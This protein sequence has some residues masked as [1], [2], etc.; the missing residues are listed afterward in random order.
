MSIGHLIVVDDG[1]AAWTGVSG[2]DC[3]GRTWLVG[4]GWRSQA[5]QALH[6]AAVKTRQQKKVN[7]RMKHTRIIMLIWCCNQCWP[8]QFLSKVSNANTTFQ[9]TSH[10]NT[11]YL[12]KAENLDFG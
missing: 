3:V 5:N 9:M 8:Y 2:P 4:S 11:C 7:L 10:T 1:S 12:L 6:I